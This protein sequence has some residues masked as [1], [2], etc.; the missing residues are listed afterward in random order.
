VSEDELTEKRHQALI[1]ACVNIFAA[2]VLL[3]VIGNRQGSIGIE[4]REWDLQTV[5]ASDYT[6]EITLSNAQINECRR[7]M[8]AN[9]FMRYDSDGLRCKLFMT[10]KLEEILKEQSG[11]DGGKVA[12]INFAYHNSWLID[13]LRE[14]GDLIK[15][16]KWKE[17]NELN[18]RLNTTMKE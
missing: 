15:F 12:D 16:G 14:R 11:K 2:L 6:L 18:R 3:S 13:A 5:T 9:Y 17:M 1:A 10:Q 4:K 7:E 8:D